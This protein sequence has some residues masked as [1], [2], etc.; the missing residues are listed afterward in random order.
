MDACPDMAGF[1]PVTGKLVIDKA[2]RNWCRLP[3]PGHPNG[4]PNF[5]ASENCPPK[6]GLVGDVFDLKREHWFVVVSFDLGSHRAK[7]LETHPDWTDRQAECCLYWQNGVRKR[8]RQACASFQEEWQGTIN[9]LIPEA[10]GVNVFES[11]ARIGLNLEKN[12]KRTV[13]KIALVGY[14]RR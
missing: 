7:M 6:V 11:A 14:P 9:T 2:T 10:M 12:P 4:C 13:Y 1:I 8:L 3:Y 5:G